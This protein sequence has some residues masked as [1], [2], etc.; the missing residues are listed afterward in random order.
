LGSGSACRSVKDKCSLATSQ[1]SS[2]DLFEWIS[3]CDSC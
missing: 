2:S 1:Y 3:A